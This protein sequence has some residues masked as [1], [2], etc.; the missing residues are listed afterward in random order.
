MPRAQVL[1][2]TLSDE[3]LEFVR[4]KVAAGEYRS[5]NDVLDRSVASLMEEEKEQERFEREE[6]MAAYEESLADP[7]SAI[8]IEQV[9][10][11]LAN[12]I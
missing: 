4:R 1:E 8:P 7:S 10:R 2:V 11:N 5:A 3:S 9:R 6:V 12:A